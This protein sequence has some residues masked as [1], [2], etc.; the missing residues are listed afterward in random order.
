M[1]TSSLT[2]THLFVPGTDPTRAPLLLLHGTGGNEQSLLPLAKKLVP[3]APLLSVRGQVLEHG[4]PRFFRRFAE[5]VFDLPD[6]ERRTE[7]LADFIVAAA[8]RY[9]LNLSRLTALG[10]S[11]GANMA[12]ALLLRRPDVLGAAALLR[13]MVVLEPGSAPDLRGKRILMLNG[14]HDP[15]VPND[16]PERLAAMFRSGGATVDARLA[17]AGH[18]LTTAEFAVVQRF[19]SA[20]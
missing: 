1:N 15:I 8:E 9:Q 12:A 20:G 2:H 14:A 7:D 19:L 6:V 16:H 4:M 17:E 11:N 13:A 3:G 10:Y 5:G 18:D